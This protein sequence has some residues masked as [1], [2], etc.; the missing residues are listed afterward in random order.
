M[1]GGL[2]LLAEGLDKRFKNVAEV[3]Q[4]PAIPFLGFI[5][6][7]TPAETSSPSADY[8]AETLV[9]SGR[10]LS[11]GAHLDPTGPAAGPEFARD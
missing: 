2:A 9:S 4:A 11:H 6:R 8:L 3:E 5:P 7:H 1:R 10:G